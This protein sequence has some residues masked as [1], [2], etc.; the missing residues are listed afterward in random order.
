MGQD[1]L[2]DTF[3]ATKVGPGPKI[4]Y[5]LGCDKEHSKP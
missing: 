5:G 4:E 2:Y 3:D 1:W